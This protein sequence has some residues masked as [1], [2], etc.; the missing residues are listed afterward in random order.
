MPLKSAFKILV[1]TRAQTLT[2]ATSWKYA[3][4]SLTRQVKLRSYLTAFTKGQIWPQVSL[5]C[6]ASHTNIKKVDEKIINLPKYFLFFYSSDIRKWCWP[7]PLSAM[8]SIAG[9][10]GPKCS[11]YLEFNPLSAMG[12]DQLPFSIYIW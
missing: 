4:C 2:P 1:F 9:V 6:T 11:N 7:Y 12:V 10:N 3:I 5:M 8:K